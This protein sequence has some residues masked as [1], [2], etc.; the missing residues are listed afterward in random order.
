MPSGSGSSERLNQLIAD[1]LMA[2]ERG[3]APNR[4]QLL[5]DH[6]ELASELVSFFSDHDAV[7]TPS[8]R[9]GLPPD[10]RHPTLDTVAQSAAATSQT[11]CR[12]GEGQS[13]PVPPGT[14]SLRTFGDYEIIE[15]IARGGMG[16]VYK[17]RQ[18]SLNRTVAVKMILAGQLATD[19]DVARFHAE[20]TAAANLDHPGIVPV[21][22]VGEQE[23]Q[24]FFSMGFVEGTSLADR[25]ALG[26]LEEI[27]AALLL[28]ALAEA[29]EYAHEQGVIHRDLKPANV[30]LKTGHHADSLGSRPLDSQEG[31]SISHREAAHGVRP[32]I[33]DFGLAKRVGHDSHLTAT[34]Q[35]LGTPSYM[36]PEQASGRL[37]QVGVASDVYS[38][39]AILYALLTG[40]PPFQ[41]ASRLDTLM[42]VLERDPVPPRV[43]NPRIHPD[44]ETVVM[45]C[46][47][48]DPRRRYGSAQDLLDEL[49]RFLRD[50]PVLARPI[51]KTARVWRWCRRQPMTA[52]LIALATFLLLAGTI[53]SSYFAF[54]ARSEA[55]AAVKARDDATEKLWASYLTQAQAQ[56]W[57]GKAG[58]R[59]DSLDVLGKAAAIR[60]SLE[61]RNEAIA[62]MALADLRVHQEWA[63]EPPTSFVEFDAGLQR[64]ARGEP[65][66]SISIRRVQG[67][68]ELLHLP[69]AGTSLEWILRFSP[70]GR[71]LVA[72]YGKEEVCRVKVW[73]LQAGEVAFEV[74][75]HVSLRAIDFHPDGRGLALVE[76]D[77]TV[78]VIDVATWS[79]TDRFAST[80]SAPYAIAFDPFGRRLAISGVTAQIVE[81]INLESGQTEKTLSHKAG[82]R[83]IAWSPDASLLAVAVANNQGRLWDVESGRSVRVFG[84]HTNVVTRVAFSAGGDLLIS[85]AWGANT[86]LWSLYQE[87]PLVRV[88]AEPLRF[89]AND[90]FLAYKSVPY[91]A[92]IWE[93]ATGHEFRTFGRAAGNTPLSWVRGAISPDGRTLVT[94]DTK[95]VQLWD[96][97]SSKQIALLPWGAQ[98][99]MFDPKRS[100]FYSAGTQ[101][102]HRWPIRME[103]GDE[104]DRLWIESPQRLKPHHVL[105]DLDISSDG[106][107]LAIAGQGKVY[108]VSLESDAAVPEAVA[109][110]QHGGVQHVAIDRS[111]RWIASA[112]WR[113]QG[114]KIWDMKSAS[115]AQD[116]PVPGDAVL[117][118]SPDGRLL[119]ISSGQCHRLLRVG[120]WE[121]LWEIPRDSAV[122]VPAAVGFSPDGRLLAVSEFGPFVHLVATDTG[123]ELARLEGERQGVLCFGADSTQLYVNAGGLI[124]GW[125][126]R[127]IRSQLAAMNLDWELP[128]YPKP[129]TRIQQRRP[130]QVVLPAQMN[131]RD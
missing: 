85:S 109:L 77:G 120:S 29:V 20:A 106:C 36:P 111:G 79:E 71:L 80:I 74:P 26:P 14:T 3:T 39:G 64:Y 69:G 87:E 16:I 27:E 45:R 63:V 56:R 54:Q 57:S 48:K 113:G 9:P 127:M 24:H 31:S 125:D 32:M 114:V 108:A 86:L 70:D 90:R 110:G 128:P 99:V 73:D 102:L 50:E 8:S 131:D 61:L 116:L 121:P 89:H 42:Q 76:P 82:V 49:D 5:K 34:G 65:D 122:G 12:G 55:I 51:G 47:E 129:T 104:G 96:T 25:I 18:V 41:A 72:K 112:T 17:A 98:T 15:E 107:T 1:Y 52:S 58:R 78:H 117:A 30:L 22:E 81:I 40:R 119:V 100:C 43:M 37:D 23:G 19:E 93:I 53:S 115:V 46:L 95:L 75:F 68:I 92:G 35:V 33:T 2:V 7:Q 94:S 105:Q 28:K 83:G 21:H 130:L 4:D 103:Q 60:P 10:K 84:Q 59:F 62:C 88:G 38:L 6:P 124:R 91:R 66:G 126:L 97:L 44:L 13:K 101:G 118:F 11:S 123:E 67:D